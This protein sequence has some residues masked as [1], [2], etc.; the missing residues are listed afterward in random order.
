MKAVGMNEIAQKLNISRNTVS[1][2]MNDRG[3]VA[4]KTKEKI[5]QTAIEM[6]YSKLP[7]HLLQEYGEQKISRN[8]LV[9]ATSPDFS[10]FWGKM[11]NGITKKL[12]SEEYNCFYNFLTFDQEQNF[13]MPEIIKTGDITGIIIM[14]IYNKDAVYEI[15]K[16]GIPT[17][18]YDLPLGM[19]CVEAKADVVITEGRE[20]IYTITKSLLEKGNH[21]LGFIGD[22]SY[23]KS[24]EERWRGFVRAHEKLN[25]P[26]QKAYC[27][28][29]KEH[30]HFY[31]GKEAECV[32][33]EL[34]QSRKS[35]PDGLICA[36]DMIA[37][38]VMNELRQN[39]YRVPE[40]IKVSGFDDI[41]YAREE[42]KK[43]TSVGVCIEEI[44]I[45]LAEQIV[46]RI[47]NPTRNYETVQ[48]YG[49]VHLRES[50]KE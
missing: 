4:D 37:Y 5:I 11:I 40:D 34:V 44:G 17:V 45:R 31:F 6:G 43:L 18:Y 8:I 38:K 49:D 47:Q 2:V 29:S 32:V 21:K 48:I 35:L 30:S 7:E 33:Q 9:L 1:K 50:T 24:I 23:C 13:I 10:S 12:A 42:E 15:A 14:N 41:D 19:N 39:G 20:G 16:L 22:V 3:V 25:I 26:I 36:N 46:W 28:T 27:F